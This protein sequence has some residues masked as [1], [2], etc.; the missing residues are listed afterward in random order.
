MR[1]LLFRLCLS[2]PVAAA[3]LVE[4]KAQEAIPQFRDYAVPVWSGDVSAPD[5]SSHPSA[6]S[7]RTRLREAAETGAVGFAGRFVITAWGC[8]T[9]C[10]TFAMLDARTGA[11]HFLPGPVITAEIDMDAD[12]NVLE[13]RPD[14]RLM[15]LSG[16]IADTGICTA[17]H[18]FEFTDDHFR[19]VATRPVPLVN[20]AD[21]YANN[22][23]DQAPVPDAAAGPAALSRLLRSRGPRPARAGPSPRCPRCRPGTSGAGTR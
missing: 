6:R 13:T 4:A 15:V 11:V 16:A 10:V 1:N 22:G 7:F 5:L 3:S 18:F 8:G 17:A 21:S 19:L 2:I 9:T 14:S 12:F 23:K 20:D